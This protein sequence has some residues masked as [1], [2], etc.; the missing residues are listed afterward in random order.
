MRCEPPHG[1]AIASGS[2]S[3]NERLIRQIC[4]FTAKVLNLFFIVVAKIIETQAVLFRIHEGTQLCL[5]DPALRCV[6]KTL[7]YG[8]LDTLPIVHALLGNLA[9]ALLPCGV[10]RIHVVCDQNQHI[11]PSFPQESRIGIQIAPEAAG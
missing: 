10:L 5:Q 2:Q 7:K 6:Q 4:A 8:T 9:Q 11:S 3:K 1:I